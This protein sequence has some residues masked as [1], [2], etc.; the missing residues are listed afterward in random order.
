MSY[1]NFRTRHEEILA[2]TL[3]YSLQDQGVWLTTC[4]QYFY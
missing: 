1:L 2:P 3:S 4:T